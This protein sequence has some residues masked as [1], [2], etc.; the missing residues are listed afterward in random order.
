MDLDQ[1]DASPRPARGR[2][3]TTRITLHGS[4]EACAQIRTALAAFAELLHPVVELDAAQAAV[5]EPDLVVVALGVDYSTWPLEIQDL[6]HAKGPRPAVVAATADRSAEAVRH[7][8]RAGADDVLFLPP[9]S[10]D[11]SRCLARGE[12]RH[13]G[14]NHS[15]S[16]CALTSVAGGAGLS[17]LTVALGFALMRLGRRR[18]A[19][20]DLDLQCGALASILDLNPEH[21]LS[22]LVDPTTTIDSIRLEAS[23]AAHPSGLYLLAAPKRLEES[24]M[25]SVSAVTAVLDLMRELFD[26][27]LIDCGH[28]ISETLVAAWESSSQLLYIVEQAVTSVRPAQRFLEMFGRLKLAEPEPQFVLNRY[29]AANPF[30]PEKIEAA[31]HHP[32]L[33]RIP[34]DNAAFLQLQIEGADLAEVAARSAGRAAIDGLA[35]KLCGMPDLG[36]G[37]PGRPLISRLRSL[38]KSPTVASPAPAQTDPSRTGTLRA[39]TASA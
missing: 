16:I 13:R 6:A 18:V 12:N 39:P 21:T 1:P 32:L 19:L 14:V 37:G 28:H 9:D 3:H 24:E 35:R 10:D 38:F 15:A 36:V 2:I 29:E 22:E 26:F 30:S 4:A 7:A 25:I 33:A 5:R 31:L 20:I 11:L 23:L 8:L 34:G 27:V 17:T